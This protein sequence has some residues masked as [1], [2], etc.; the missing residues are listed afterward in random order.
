M[1]SEL[2]GGIEQGRV[3][4]WMPL[5]GSGLGGWS[6]GVAVF[7]DEPAEN[8]NALDAGG[9]AGG[10]GCVRNAGWRR[11][12]QCETAMWSAGRGWS[13]DAGAV[14]QPL[15]P[16]AMWPAFPT[17]DY[18]GGSAPPDLFGGRCAYPDPQAGYP[19]I[20]SHD[21]VVPVFTVVRSSKEEPDCVPAASPWV[22][23]RPSPWPPSPALVYLLEVSHPT[24]H[25]GW[26]RTAPSP[27]PPDL[28]RWRC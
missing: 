9:T 23:R 2:V 26:L 28:S 13:A 6:G 1:P 19:P 16:F 18:Y 10:S 25:I 21:R 17:S 7:V 5:R 11:H 12:R 4:V 14:S 24:L 20:G 8:A 3:L 27:Y 15:P 22:R